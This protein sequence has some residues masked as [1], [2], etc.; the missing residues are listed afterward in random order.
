MPEEDSMN[1][2]FRLMTVGLGLIVVASACLAQQAERE[3]PSAKQSSVD[4]IVNRLLAF[5]KNNDGKLTKDEI[6]D[7]RL[8]RLFDRADANK[9]GVVTKEELVALA[10]EM[11]ADDAKNSGR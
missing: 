5:D 3:P 7:V 10:T 2:V 1:L 11:V 9:E 4:P 8:H 6:G